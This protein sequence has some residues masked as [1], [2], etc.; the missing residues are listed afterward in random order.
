MVLVGGNGIAGHDA[1]RVGDS[2][3]STKQSVATCQLD[4]RKNQISDCRNIMYNIVGNNSDICNMA[5]K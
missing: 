2:I 4:W 5:T 3:L 1:W